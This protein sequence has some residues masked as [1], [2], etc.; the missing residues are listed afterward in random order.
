MNT[1]PKNI[2]KISL[3]KLAFWSSA[4]VAIIL[5][6]SYGYLVNRAILSAVAYNNTETAINTLRSDVGQLEAKYI[7]MKK[8]IDM[9]YAE[10][11]GFVGMANQVVYLEQD[12]LNK[13]LSLNN[14]L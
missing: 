3:M 12:N 7:A 4:L 11:H 5:L 14:G 13:G 1:A 8:P 2:Y 9:A 6:F 10:S